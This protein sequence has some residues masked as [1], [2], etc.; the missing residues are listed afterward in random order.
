MRERGKKSF[1]VSFVWFWIILSG[2]EKFWRQKK[3]SREKQRTKGKR[4]WNVREKQAYFNAQQWRRR[5][6]NLGWRKPFKMY[7]IF[8][9]FNVQFL[10]TIYY[11]KLWPGVHSGRN[12]VICSARVRMY[13]RIKNW[14]FCA[15]C[16]AHTQCS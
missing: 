1:G 7:T 9:V 6:I 13:I 5:S 8:L 16:T 15:V 4:F 3:R 10:R 2:T 11:H 14:V 12:S